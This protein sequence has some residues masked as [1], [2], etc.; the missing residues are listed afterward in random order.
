MYV[1]QIGAGILIALTN[2]DVCL[3]SIKMYIKCAT[4]DLATVLMFIKKG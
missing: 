2:Y 3:L 1:D 4:D